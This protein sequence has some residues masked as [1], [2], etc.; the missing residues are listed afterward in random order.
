MQDFNGWKNYKT[1]NVAL[2]IKNDS[3]LYN[4]A[5]GCGDYKEFVKIMD[6]FK[7]SEIAEEDSKY[8]HVSRTTPDSVA[9][10][11]SEL[12]IEALDQL[13]REL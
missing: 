7:G 6:R 9:W 11:D 8:T 3:G 13:I 1:W 5:I 2:W 10:N 12:D 4:I